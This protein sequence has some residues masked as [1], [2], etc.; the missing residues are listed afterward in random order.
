MKYGKYSS[1]NR[2]RRL[3][4][5]KQFVLLASVAIL[6]V[7]VVGGS[8]AYLLTNT[9]PVVNTFT[10]GNVTIEVDE[11]FDG[12]VKENV[13]I[14]NTGN[15][16]AYIRARVVVTWQDDSRNIYPAQPA[17]GTDYTISWRKDGWTGPVNGVYT[18]T[19]SVAPGGQ[20][21]VLFTACQPVA[22]KTPAGYH[23]VVDVIAEAIQAGG[24]AQ[25]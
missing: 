20:T 22:N 18:H 6:L 1:D 3:R 14:E 15:V 11:D 13:K 8:L 16:D 5:S 25:W 2:K 24:G 17:E 21:G 23:L 10:P 7:G 4:W 9:D 19:N 12:S